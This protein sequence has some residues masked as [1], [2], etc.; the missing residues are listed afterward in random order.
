MKNRTFALLGILWLLVIGC[1]GRDQDDYGYRLMAME[2]SGKIDSTFMVQALSQN[3]QKIRMAAVRTCGIVGDGRFAGRMAELCVS[4]EKTE[5]LGAIFSLGEIKDTTS[6]SVLISLFAEGSARRDIDPE[7]RVAAIRAIGKIGLKEAA[8]DLLKYNEETD[9]ESIEKSLALWRLEAPGSIEYLE[10]LVD[11]SGSEVVYSAVYSLFR[12]APDSAGVLFFRVLMSGPRGDVPEL[13]GEIQ[14]IA[15]R[16]LVAAGDSVRLLAVYDGQYQN[17]SRIGRMEAVRGLGKLKTGRERLEKLVQETDDNG[18]KREIILALGQIGNSSSLNL[19]KKYL[20][21]G[22]LQVRLAAIS[23]LPEINGKLTWPLLKNIARDSLWQLRAEAARALGKTKAKSAQKQLKMMLEDSD[24]R[25]RAA[26][27]GALGD[28]PVKRDLDIFK[29]AMFGSADPVVRSVAVDVL[30]SSGDPGA[31]ELLLEAASKL[32]S[33]YGIDYSRSLVAAL[34]TFADS[35]DYGPRALEAIGKFLNHPDRIVRQDAYLAMKES[36]PADFDLGELT[37]SFDEKYY[38]YI[39]E[40]AEREIIAMIITSRGSI[41]VQL[42]TENAPRTAAN[43]VRLAE[44]E[45]YDG[46]IFHRVVQNFVIQGGCPRGDGW[47][48]PGYMIRE[49][50]NPAPFK[51]GTIGMATSGKDTGGSQFFI[52][53]SAQPHLDGRYTTF[54]RVIGGENVLDSIEMGDEIVSIT[55]EKR[56]RP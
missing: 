11:S 12:L 40:N 25:V 9:M 28:Y 55:I 43:F 34:G 4:G 16:G 56:R 38:D 23:A 10:S 6:V 17:L 18:L 41:E 50:I 22:S 47:G 29:A 14:A 1:S 33:T 51:R 21:D 48:D 13:W 32:D 45:F 26:V 37:N 7:I 30:G 2:E 49:E 24:N 8:S 3:D 19:I 52:C 46:L 27:I 15:L 39:T 20:Y 5:R 54:G 36:A 35:A 31:F 42:D 53:H 44:R